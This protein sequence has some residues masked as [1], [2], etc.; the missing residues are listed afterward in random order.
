MDG[1]DIEVTNI[2]RARRVFFDA[3]RKPIIV[4][5]GMTIKATVSK[6]IYERFNQASETGDSLKVG[7]SIE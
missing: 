7:K 4:D 2:G 1:K 6:G 5:P 3:E